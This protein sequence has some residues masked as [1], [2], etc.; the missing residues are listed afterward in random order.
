MLKTITCRQPFAGLIAASLKPVENRGQNFAHRGELAIHAGK[1]VDPAEL[2][3][4]QATF[5]DA[6]LT[7]LGAVLAVAELT[8]CHL[9]DGCCEPWGF[10]TYSGGPAFHLTIA[11]VRRLARPVECRGQLGLWSLPPDVEAAVR[12]QLPM[13]EEAR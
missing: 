10:P 12:S 5:P 3:T 11:H 1:A 7:V 4:M 13:P 8:G 9:A 2:V 6:P